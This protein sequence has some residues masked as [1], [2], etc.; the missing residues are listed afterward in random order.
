MNPAIALPVRLPAPTLV[1][2][3]TAVSTVIAA[4]TAAI[5][6]SPTGVAPPADERRSAHCPVRRFLAW[7]N[8]ARQISG[9]WMKGRLRANHLGR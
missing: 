7:R 4:V 3:L 9:T 1:S 2:A 6:A 8:P 5:A